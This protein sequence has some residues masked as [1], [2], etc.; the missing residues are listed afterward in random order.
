MIFIQ[1]KPINSYFKCDY[2]L[3]QCELQMEMSVAV[4]DASG[5]WKENTYIHK[6]P[7]ACSA[8]KK[9]LGNTFTT[10][11]KGFG[12]PDHCPYPPVYNLY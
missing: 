2:K 10:C 8:M 11:A 1:L 3:F 7:K 4:R 6:I 12:I 9:M 5:K